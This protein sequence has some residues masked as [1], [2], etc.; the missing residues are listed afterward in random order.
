MGREE[1]TRTGTHVFYTARRRCS[2]LGKTRVTD[3]SCQVCGSYG[4]FWPAED[5]RQI[6]AIIQGATYHRDLVQMGIIQPGDIILQFDR[7]PPG[8]APEDRIRLDPHHLF[9]FAIANEASVL[10]RGDGPCDTTPQRI[11]E[12]FTIDRSEPRTG[13]VT[14]FPETGY[15]FGRDTNVLTWTGDPAKCE[16]PFPGEQYAVNY[17]ADYDWVVTNP[18]GPSGIGPVGLQGKVVASRRL[19]DGRRYDEDRAEPPIDDL[20]LLRG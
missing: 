20:D 5:E 18:S 17:Q 2:C 3:I 15:S 11:V 12:I 10:T 8:L 4:W 13:V 1:H 9:T 14:T 16:A 19:K 6:R 7:N